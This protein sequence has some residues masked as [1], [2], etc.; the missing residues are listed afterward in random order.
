MQVQNAQRRSPEAAVRDRGKLDLSDMSDIDNKDETVDAD[1][2][3]PG[4]MNNN[5]M[6]MEKTAD[7]SEVKATT[8]DNK[9]KK[10]RVDEK[11][12]NIQIA[13]NDELL[14]ASRR[15]DLF[16]LP[17]EGFIY[18]NKLP[19]CGS[20]TMHAILGVLSRWNNFRYLKLEPSLV[21]F[22]DGEKMSTL[23]NTLLLRY[24]LIFHFLNLTNLNANFMIL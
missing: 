2:K 14:E 12:L 9:T 3:P 1:F 16:Q 7:E 24:N 6:Q 10:V 11:W 15:R 8:V 5:I 4:D 20:T 17:N 13:D 19:K 21:K 23:I 18:H 22:Y